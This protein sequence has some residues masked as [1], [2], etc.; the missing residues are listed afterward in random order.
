MSVK[1]RNEDDLMMLFKYLIIARQALQRRR[2]RSLLTILGIIAG[3]GSIT[4]L[5]NVGLGAQKQIIGDNGLSED[6]LTVRS[7]QVVSR[8]QDGNITQY[9]L[10]QAVG[11]ASTLTSADLHA[12]ETNPQ[13]AQSSPVVVLNEEI[14]DLAGDKF[15][16]GHVIAAK[17]ELLELID[18]EM[19]N[20]SNTLNSNRPTA[21]IG[22]EVAKEFF[23][24]S[25]PISHEIILGDQSF[26][27]V[28]VLKK[29]PRLNPLNIS[30]NYRRAVLVPFAAIEE[31]NA[32]TQTHTLIYEI[33]ARTHSDIGSQLIDD[34]D[35]AIL[36]NHNQKQEFTVFKNNEL[37][38][39]TSSIF[40]ILRNLILVIG[41]IFLLVAGI[42][43]MNAMQASVA[44]RK[45]EIGLR[46]AVG[47]TNQ[48]I[49]HQFLV[50]ALLLSAIG[51][52]L[53]VIT[54][55]ILGLLINYWTPIRP[56]IQLDIV[57]LMLI[58]APTLGMLFGSQ[59]AIQAAIQKP[60]EHLK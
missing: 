41:L 42:G 26:I 4:L 12:I 27:V 52:I 38:F 13:I 31:I 55:L 47:A 43:L 54:A 51:G 6:L 58:L 57:I 59:G 11:V 48:Q 7:G 24:N 49:F 40:K 36:T 19:A 20:G 18:Y 17:G 33:I 2:D 8:N 10:A 34:I 53:G 9:N 30:F 56:V 14:E 46:K 50:E 1:P 37:T 28:G 25:R 21:I 45:L 5:I 15:S 32:Q 3:I 22:D 29:P 35:S 44:E 60:S 39:L 23:N 16:H